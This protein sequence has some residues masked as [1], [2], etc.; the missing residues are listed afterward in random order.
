MGHAARGINVA[1]LRATCEG[2]S[3][4]E[5]CLPRGLDQTE[6]EQL[7][8]IVRPSR[9]IHAG[10]YLYDV[11]DPFQSLYAV[12]SGSIEAYIYA[13][14]GEEEVLGFYMPGDLLG[15]DGLLN[16]SHTCS[17]LALETSSVCRLPFNTLG[18]LCQKLPGLQ[19]EMYRLVGKEL[20]KEQAVL[21]AIRRGNAAGRLAQ[22]LLNMSKRL[23]ER[24]LAACEI[25]LSM[26]RKHIANYLGLT[27][28]T[29]CRVF[30]RFNETGLLRV[31]RRHC[32]ILDMPALETV[33]G[34]KD[35]EAPQHRLSLS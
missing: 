31:E 21:L 10:D 25:H 20:S 23:A 14:S 16:G 34:E 7:E 6:L 12:R 22:F 28:A 2:C 3:L 33:A 9:P 19:Q 5:L 18:V 24:G 32:Q 26:S 17:A 1:R 13:L 30:A 4:A 11:G 15:L 29:V 27:E 8:Q 35:P